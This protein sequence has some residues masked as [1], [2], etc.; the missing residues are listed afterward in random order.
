MPTTLTHERGVTVYDAARILQLPG[1]TIRGA[2]QHGAVRATSV[3]GRVRISLEELE[4]Y[5][6]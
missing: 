4:R 2:I 3:D 5:R 1:S 6:Q